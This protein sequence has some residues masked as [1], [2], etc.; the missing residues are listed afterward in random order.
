[1]KTALFG[2]DPNWG[3]IACAAG[4]A[5]V[6]L[7]PERLSV[8]I[9]GVPVLRARGAGVG[10]RSCGAPR[11]S[12][13]TPAFRDHGRPRDRRP[14]HGDDDHERPHARLRALQ[15][16]LLDVNAEEVTRVTTEDAST[17]KRCNTC[18]K[19]I[20]FASGYFTCNV[21]T[22][23]RKGTDFAFCSVSC[24]DAHVP[25]LRHR[26]AWAEEQQAPTAAA[27]AAQPARSRP[28]APRRRRRA[29]PAAGRAAVGAAGRARAA[30]RSRTTS[31]SWSR[32]SRP[33]CAPVRHEHAPTA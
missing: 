13:A 29:A 2:G 24:W 6:P 32:S 25:V 1:M 31:W 4:Y 21:S 5:G 26:D 3:R 18:K 11:P 27:W 33:T 9:G 15:L 22:C 23:N 10:R 14:R 19:P 17:W 20:A 12:C 28:S 8:T 16:R 7:A 30:S